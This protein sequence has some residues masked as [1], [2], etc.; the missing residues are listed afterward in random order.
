MFIFL[1]LIVLCFILYLIDLIDGEMF[2]LFTCMFIAGMAIFY[3]VTG[4]AIERG[5]RI[6]AFKTECVAS[7]GKLSTGVNAMGI[8]SYTCVEP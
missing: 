8:T 1:A 6:D 7:G 4:I 5:A 3:M 2:F